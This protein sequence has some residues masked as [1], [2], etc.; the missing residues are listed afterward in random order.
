MHCSSLAILS[1]ADR[2][3]FPLPLIGKNWPYDVPLNTNQSISHC[4]LKLMERLSKNLSMHN[5][6]KPSGPP[7]DLD[8]NFIAVTERN[9]PTKIIKYCRI[10]IV[11][12][13]EVTSTQLSYRLSTLSWNEATLTQLCF[14]RMQW[15]PIG[16][17]WLLWRLTLIVPCRH[18]VALKPVHGKITIDYSDVWL[19]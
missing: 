18:T 10:K 4:K 11:L 7:L 6:G 12:T 2:A 1:C 5:C 3:W 8:L 15:C 14:H 13:I 16:W 19:W 9:V 17:P